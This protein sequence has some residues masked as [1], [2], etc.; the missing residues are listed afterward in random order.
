VGLAR[1]ITE[2]TTLNRRPFS[3]ERYPFQEAIAD[4][5][6]PKLSCEKCSQIGLTEIQIRKFFA[7]LRRTSGINGIF[8]LPNDTM[9]KRIYNGRMKPIL[10]ADPIFNPPMAIKPIRNMDMTQIFDSFGYQTGCKEG[11][12]T[13]ISADIRTCVQHRG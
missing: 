5:E 11:D 9:F 3:Y 4:D 13:S 7:M 8:T 6:H 1:W 2:N 12:A 10:E